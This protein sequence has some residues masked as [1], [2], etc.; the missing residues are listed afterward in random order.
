VV[1]VLAATLA[2]VS[3]QLAVEAQKAT[4][5]FQAEAA[6]AKEQ[7]KQEK[8]AEGTPVSDEQA[9]KEG[10]GNRL[11]EYAGRIPWVGGQLAQVDWTAV[12]VEGRARE[13]LDRMVGSSLVVVKGAGEIAIQSLVAVFLIFFLLRD[14]HHLMAEAKKFIPL[15]G[16]AAD[17]VMKRAADAIH[18]TVYGTVVTAVLQGATGGLLFWLLDLPAPVLWAV[19][20]T[21][22]G[23][24]PVVGA[25]LVWAPAAVYL[26]SEGRWGAAV[27]LAAWGLIMAGPV[28]NWLYAKLAGDRMRLHAVPTL[29]AFIGGLA[30]FGVS[31]MILGPCI[32]AVTVALVS[33][34]RHRTADGTPVAVQAPTV[35][36]ATAATPVLEPAHT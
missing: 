25:F 30:V 31:G 1:L 27:G 23:I 19:V 10:T 5:R 3:W 9:A 4:A 16:D 24:L 33:M 12:D 20:M 6:A 8:A 36:P 35:T 13:L 7:A 18:A 34:W 15:A 2:L 22:L 32:L 14:R 29:L 28:C 21:V 17:R 11:R 26:A